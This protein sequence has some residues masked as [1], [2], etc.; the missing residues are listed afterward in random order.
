MQLVVSVCP[1]V[2]LCSPAWSVW[3]AKSSKSHYQ[4]RVFVCL[5]VVRGCIGIIVWMQSISFNA[6]YCRLGQLLSYFFISD[7]LT[8]S[9][10]SVP[11]LKSIFDAYHV[12]RVFTGHLWCRSWPSPQQWSLSQLPFSP[13]VCI[14]AWFDW[15]V[16]QSHL[17][18]LK[19][20]LKSLKRFRSSIRDLFA[21]LHI[22]SVC[23]MKVAY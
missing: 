5:S 16:Y 23:R 7:K 9:K 3:P 19:N 4:S 12:C 11:M 15:I 22:S 13:T 2:C 14:F 21:W 20:P 1:S 18:L 6:F 8:V 17:E 10:L